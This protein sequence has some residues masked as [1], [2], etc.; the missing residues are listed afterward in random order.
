MKNAGAVREEAMFF[1]MEMRM[2]RLA[3]STSSK[4]YFQ[5]LKIDF[6]LA[7]L[8]DLVSG[9]GISIKRAIVSLLSWNVL[10]FLTFLLLLPASCANTADCA[11]A[12]R[13]CRVIEVTDGKAES[14]PGPGMCTAATLAAQNAVN[15]ASVLSS[16]SA[17]LVHSGLLIF[18][19]LL[20]SI[21]SLSIGA[22]LL[23]A[24]RNNFHRGN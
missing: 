24:I 17:V 10:F 18:L 11:T 1:G 4:P 15:P 22:L 13:S 7:Y 2:R 6:L 16:G 14:V 20:Q 5:L 19:S 23:L 9:Y 8:Y 12:S 3:F 21:G